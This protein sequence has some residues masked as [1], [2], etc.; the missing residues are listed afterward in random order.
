[1]KK[2]FRIIYIILFPLLICSCGKDSG[3]DDP[4]EPEETGKVQVY[5]SLDGINRELLNDKDIVTIP[6]G[7][8]FLFYVDISDAS[9]VL[10]YSLDYARDNLQTGIDPFNFED[11]GNHQ[12]LFST[13]K[14]G[15]FGISVFVN[16]KV[17]DFD[18]YLAGFYIDVPTTDY[19]IISLGTPIYTIDVDDDILK[20]EIANELGTKYNLSMKPLTLAGNTLTG[21][22]Y[23][24]KES[25]GQISNGTF[26]STN[27]SDL[28]DLSFMYNDLAFSYNLVSEEDGEGKYFQF[29]QDLTDI[30]QGKYPGQIIN[31]VSLTFRGFRNKE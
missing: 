3:S 23:Q 17:D 11:K 27:T 2:Y 8:A 25:S 29:T 31:E 6:L 22:T 13:N 10:D 20:T 24:L 4:D 28:T 7:G 30:Y 1:M 19:T 16:F 12:Y 26:T 15:V 9:E 14:S 21:G 18:Y 5:Y